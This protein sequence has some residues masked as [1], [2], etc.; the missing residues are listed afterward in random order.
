MTQPALLDI[1]GS[2]EDPHGGVLAEEDAAAREVWR[3]F[4]RAY[5]AGT[6]DELLAAAHV[7]MDVQPADRVETLC[8]LGAFLLARGEAAEARQVFDAALQAL[9]DASE[10]RPA[11]INALL[12][13]AAAHLAAGRSRAALVDAAAAAEFY[14]ATPDFYVGDANPFGGPGWFA[15]M[16]SAYP[17]AS[18]LRALNGAALEITPTLRGRLLFMEYVAG[19]SDDRDLRAAATRLLGDDPAFQIIKEMAGEF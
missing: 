17:I 3:T 16:G 13:R 7:Y 19:R 9:L 11:T 4:E 14:F 1:V 10:Y 6:V 2:G 15:Q 12:G 18:T 8:V 5:E